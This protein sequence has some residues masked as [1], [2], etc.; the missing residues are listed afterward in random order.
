MQGDFSGQ[1]LAGRTVSQVW[2]CASC[3]SVLVLFFSGLLLESCPF[4][5]VFVFHSFLCCSVVRRPFILSPQ[6][7]ALT[8]PRR[9]C[10]CTCLMSFISL[11]LFSRPVAVL[12]ALTTASWCNDVSIIS[13]KLASLLD[14]GYFLRLCHNWHDGT[15]HRCTASLHH[16]FIHASFSLCIS[17]L[18][19]SPWFKLS[20]IS[21]HCYK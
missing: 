3:V 11:C 19:S 14:C 13:L 17:A 16:Y 8:L 20:C 4:S 7:T 5:C 21:H 15:M 18:F 6:Y 9:P 2:T 10:L 12:S 1:D